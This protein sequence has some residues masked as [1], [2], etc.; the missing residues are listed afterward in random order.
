M[1]LP[2][3]YLAIIIHLV[4]ISTQI[5]AQRTK[6]IQLLDK[7]TKLPVPYA[8]IKII[9]KPIGTYSDDKGRFSL[10]LNDL[11]TIQI[12]SIGY[13]DL[14][15]TDRFKDTLELQPAATILKPVTIMNKKE[16][17]QETLGIVT[18]KSF[19]WGPSG[20]GE[21]FAQ[22]INIKLAENEYFRINKV[23]IGVSSFSE[24]TPTLLHIY[25]V[26]KSTGMP[27]KEILNKKHLL[28]KEFIKRKIITINLVD[29]SLILDD[30][31]VFVSIEWLGFRENKNAKTKKTLLQMTNNIQETLTYSRNF[32]TKSRVWFQAPKVNNI[33]TNTI[34][35]INVTRY[36]Y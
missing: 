35:T 4:S 6:D 27:G 22:K 28:Y 25:T 11:D 1:H 36:R 32:I 29:D 3:R 19:E 7:I 20:L 31:S 13:E 14:V 23:T 8:T 21:E 10:L 9:G 17:I 12:T 16:G 24:D 34:F 18:S 26:D 5:T 15:Q 30:N 33:V 2:T